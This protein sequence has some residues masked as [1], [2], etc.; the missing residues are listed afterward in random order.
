MSVAGEE[1]EG[2]HYMMQLNVSIKIAIFN[3]LRGLCDV[4]VKDLG[5]QPKLLGLNP[6]RGDS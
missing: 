3:V 1:R 5:W 6:V 4:E 2:G